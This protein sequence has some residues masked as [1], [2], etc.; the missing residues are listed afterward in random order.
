M[1]EKRAG[2]ISAQVL[3][4]PGEADGGGAG[5][6][7]GGWRRVHQL[8][9]DLISGNYFVSISELGYS[10][11]LRM[12]ALRLLVWVWGGTAAFFRRS[13]PIEGG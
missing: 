7:G 2:I 6:G 10:L 4:Q 8:A 1:P 12:R 11:L 3:A 9:R 5:D 13:P